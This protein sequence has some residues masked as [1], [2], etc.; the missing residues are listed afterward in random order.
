[1]PEK[2]HNGPI[3]IFDSGIGGLNISKA[4]VD[5]FPHESFLYFGDTV[6]LPYGDKSPEAIQRYSLKIARFLE[7]QGAKLIVIA[8]NSASAAAGDFL[9]EQLRIPVIDVIRPLIGQVA[10][11]QALQKVGI[12]A[13]KATIRSD[14][15]ARSLQQLRPDIEVISLATGLLAPLIE[16]GF[17]NN[18]V[19]QA[20]VQNYLSYPDFSGIDA[21]LLACTHYPLI[22]PE[23]EAYFG[24]SVQLYDAI[25]PLCQS[26]FD[27]LQEL[28]FA[29]SLQLGSKRFY[30]SDYT[31][32]FAR[33]AAL[34]YGK[35]VHLE[36][37][38]VSI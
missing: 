26:V 28:G 35:N 38:R 17:V 21:L 4:L 5:A 9:R 6:H 34:F 30:V 7:E 37:S 3:G 29:S 16:E 10:R 31:Q 22:R 20:V 1:M 11:E 25:E 8:C 12:I 13:T 33:T 23:I 14:M 18:T 15:Y 36:L 27:A 32:S 19:S 24:K 2:Q